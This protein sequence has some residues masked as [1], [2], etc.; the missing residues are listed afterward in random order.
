[1]E[2]RGITVIR[3]RAL[4]NHMTPPEVKLWQNLRRR[5]LGGLR[6]RRQHPMGPWILDFFCAECMLAVEV[7]GWIH[8]R[9]D[10]PERDRR[11]D[12]WLA[13]QGVLVVRVSG[14]SVMKETGGVLNYILQAAQSRQAAPKTT[15]NSCSP[16]G[17]AGRLA[18]GEAD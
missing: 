13:G 16:I 2:A 10:I 12:N 14:A 8:E 4:R 17:G 5:Q 6:F 7:D 18:I 15:Q 9:A 11:R 3:A 1:M